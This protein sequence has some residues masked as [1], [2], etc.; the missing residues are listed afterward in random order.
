MIDWER[1][2]LDEICDNL[3]LLNIGSSI[4]GKSMKN[5]CSQISEFS[6]SRLHK[7]SVLT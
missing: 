6:L 5:S 1:L 3:R 4:Y 7:N 2:R